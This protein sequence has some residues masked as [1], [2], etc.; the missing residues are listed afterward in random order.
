MLLLAL[1]FVSMCNILKGVPTFSP[2]VQT[3]EDN[4]VTLDFR[5]YGYV[6]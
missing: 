1:V 3:K 6:K 2:C 4:N 5:K